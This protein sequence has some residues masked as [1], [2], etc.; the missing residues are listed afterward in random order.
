MPPTNSKATGNS[1]LILGSDVMNIKYE[2]NVKDIDN[3]T[4]AQ[5]Q[6]QKKGEN[7]PVVVTLIR[8]KDLTPTGPVDGLLAEGNITADK[9]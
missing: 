4:T 7:G 9:L 2:V 8:F 3:V 6:Q 5:I 1:T